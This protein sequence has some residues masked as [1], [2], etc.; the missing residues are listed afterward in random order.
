V[1]AFTDQSGNI[2][3]NDQVLRPVLLTLCIME[4]D[5]GDLT[6]RIHNIKERIFGAEDENNPREIKASDLLNPKSITKRTNNKQLADE[7]LNLIQSYRVSV[8][9][10]VMERPEQVMPLEKA[11][12]LPNRFRFL[13]ERVSFDANERKSMALLVY[14]EDAKDKIMWKAINNFLFKHNFGKTLN[15]LEMPLFVK[16]IITPG[17]QVAD[18]MAGVI[19]H[20]FE[21][22]L[23][24]K[25]PQNPFEKW[26]KELYTIVRGLS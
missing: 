15:I 1:L 6:R 23:H 25:E 3:M 18:L 21:N 9:A 4:S 26:I 14:D 8:F 13:L 11:E 17:V 5:V 20:Y 22:N 24:K 16:S 2:H 7:V 12:I 10:C 19:R